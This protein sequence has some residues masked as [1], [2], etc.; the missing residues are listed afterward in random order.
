MTLTVKNTIKTN[1]ANSKTIIK[2][3]TINKTNSL[4]NSMDIMLLLDFIFFSKP[5]ILCDG[6]CS[7]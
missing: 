6:S 1:F 5:Q 3:D 4:L 7:V 2:S